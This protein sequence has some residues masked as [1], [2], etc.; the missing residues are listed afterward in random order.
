VLIIVTVKW[1]FSC[2]CLTFSLFCNP[3]TFVGTQYYIITK[4]TLP[5]YSFLTFLKDNDV[6]VL[7]MIVHVVDKKVNNFNAVSIT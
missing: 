2:L 6:R 1:K 5:L 3:V 7:H 4:E